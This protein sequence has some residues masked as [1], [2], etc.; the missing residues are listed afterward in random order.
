METKKKANSAPLK[1]FVLDGRLERPALPRTPLSQRCR[2][3]SL[4]VLHLF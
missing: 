3:L 2:W 4:R 1:G